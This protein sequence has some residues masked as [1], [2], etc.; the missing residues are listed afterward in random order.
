MC[1]YYTIP[2]HL[3]Q[4]IQLIHTEK[5][6]YSR[7]KKKCAR[8]KPNLLQD[9]DVDEEDGEDCEYNINL[10]LLENNSKKRSSPSYWP[11]FNDQDRDRNTT[12]PIRTASSHL[13]PSLTN[14][15]P[16]LHPM[17]ILQQSSSPTKS[18]INIARSNFL[19]SKTTPTTT[20]P[21]SNITSTRHD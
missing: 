4:L 21:T 8:L 16:L 1:M 15:P 17:S 18:N 20:T 10:L 3:L 12:R 14:P 13:Q 9:E 5:E 6:S 11:F 2:Y 7:R 19:Y